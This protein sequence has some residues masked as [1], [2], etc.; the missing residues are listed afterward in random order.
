MAEQETHLDGLQQVLDYRF[1]KP[2]LLQQALIHRSF[3]HENPQV[4]EADNE[5]L[6][7]LGDAVLGLAIS[8][9]LLRQ[10]PECNEGDLSRL[11][12]AIVNER[13]LARIAQ[14]LGFGDYLMLGKGEEL[15]GGRQKTSLLADTL[16]AVLAAIYLDGGLDAAIDVIK[17][18]FHAYLDIEQEQHPLRTLDK[19]YKTQLQELTQARFKLTPVYSLDAEEGPD[20][21]KTF[22]MSVALE[23]RVLAT[24]S[25]KSKKEAQ[26]EAACKALDVIG[27]QPDPDD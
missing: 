10:Y 11:R 23:N 3:L 13:E 20:H 15:T 14:D 7:F 9:L 25:G 18:L 19:D 2:G 24:G 16:E 4:N 5:T 21:D 26:Q 17:R 6:E 1:K 27:R 8:H 12:S 22:H